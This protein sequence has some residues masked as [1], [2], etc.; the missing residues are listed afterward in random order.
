MPTIQGAQHH[1][2]LLPAKSEDVYLI[3]KA[4]ISKLLVRIREDAC[5]DDD[6][7]GSARLRTPVG[8]TAEVTTLDANAI[9]N[10]DQTCSDPTIG[11][12]CST[13]RVTND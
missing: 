10:G 12:V 13:G 6:Q 9:G 1:I 4:D 7:T 3:G 11:D 8:R 5:C 2:H